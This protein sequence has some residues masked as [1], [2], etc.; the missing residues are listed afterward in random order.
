MEGV[1]VSMAAVVVAV[2]AGA[3]VVG[4]AMP[5]DAVARVG[6]AERVAATAA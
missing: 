4:A 3:S 5:A 6:W 2:R 1:A